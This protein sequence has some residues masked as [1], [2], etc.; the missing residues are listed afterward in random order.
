MLKPYSTPTI[1]YELYRSLVG[2]KTAPIEGMPAAMVDPH[3]SYISRRQQEKT[4][5]EPVKTFCDNPLGGDYR[6]DMD[7]SRKVLENQSRVRDDFKDFIKLKDYD[8][9]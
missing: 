7:Y 8:L 3:D 9:N 4:T 2:Q 6:Q 5:L 1:E